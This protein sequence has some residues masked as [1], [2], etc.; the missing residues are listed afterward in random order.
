[1]LK[2]STIKRLLCFYI[3]DLVIVSIIYAV[4]NAFTIYQLKNIG[5]LLLPIPFL[6]MGQFLGFSTYKFLDYCES[7]LSKQT[8]FTIGFVMTSILLSVGIFYAR[9]PDW[10]H[11]KLYGQMEENQKSMQ[12]FLKDRHEKQGFIAYDKFKGQFKT[13]NDFDLIGGSVYASD[14]SIN[15]ISDTLFSYRFKY[16]RNN[17]PEKYVAKINVFQDIAYLVLFNRKITSDRETIIR[18]SLM[19]KEIKNTVPNVDELFDSIKKFER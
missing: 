13:A 10:E 2:L 8:A 5:F 11:K 17:N 9:Y 6:L 4:F 1:M 3:I 15:G 7:N 12:F 16:L 14:T 19:E 18:D